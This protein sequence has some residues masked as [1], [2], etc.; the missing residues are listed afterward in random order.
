MSE[1]PLHAMASG[2]GSETPARRKGKGRLRVDQPVG[3]GEAHG[4]LEQRGGRETQGGAA[5]WEQFHVCSWRLGG[6]G[7]VRTERGQPVVWLMNICA[8]FCKL[9]SPFG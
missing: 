3:A 7:G 4:R 6:G 9:P 5:G 8:A 1:V 2:K